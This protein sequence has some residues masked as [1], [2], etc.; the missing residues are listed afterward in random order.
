V[1][2]RLGGLKDARSMNIANRALIRR[3]EAE[4]V[5]AILEIISACRREY[6]LESRV[7]SILE[8]TAYGILEVYRR[9]RSRYF[10]AV[11]D[12]HIAGGGGIAPLGGANPQTCELQ[13]MYLRP[14]NRHLRVGHALFAACIEQAIIGDIGS[15]MAMPKLY[16]R[17]RLQLLSMSAMDFVDWPRRSVILAMVITTVG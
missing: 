14:E 12:G 6:G 1:R 4:D 9:E 7:D 2:I 5:S 10:V 13:R 15:N 16:P 8:P 11:I 17:W 3:L